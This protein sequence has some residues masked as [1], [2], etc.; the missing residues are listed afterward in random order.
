MY[1]HA[2]LCQWQLEIDRMFPCG[3]I[4][5]PDDGICDDCHACLG[6]QIPTEDSRSLALSDLTPPYTTATMQTTVTAVTL[7][8]RFWRHICTANWVRPPRPAEPFGDPG[9]AI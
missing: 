8:T 3:I 4:A 5:G 1:E 9:R 2:F 6:R 7:H